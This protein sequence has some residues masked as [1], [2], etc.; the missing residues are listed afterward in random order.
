MNS[1][2]R[3]LE[4]YVRLLNINS[5][6]NDVSM[7][8]RW[9]QVFDL[10]TEDPTIEDDVV[11]C[12]QALRAEL[13]LLKAKLE[14]RGVSDSLLQPGFARLRHISS[15]AIL[16]SGWS[17]N[18]EDAARPE[19]R[20]P[21]MWANWVLRDEDEDDMPANEMAQLR[22]ELDSLEKS[23]SETDMS[24]YLRGFV[25]R[26]VDTI[27]TALKVYQA[28]GVKPIET[29]L[30]QV[31][32][33]YIVERPRIEA[34]NAKASEP[35]RSVLARAGTIIEKIAKVADNLDKIKKAGEGAYTIAATIGPAMLHWVQ[36][37]PK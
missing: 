30:Q 19:N 10:P 3:L 27:R 25:Q 15:T 35:A 26:Q 29:A 2:G 17:G 34:E 18:R 24:P 9:A 21:F 12:L 37:A 16:N 32:G 8:K 28:Q 31:A 6:G 20:I 5:G 23:L 22:A 4:I 1:A 14:A 36:S 11:T 33:A 7:T 13:D